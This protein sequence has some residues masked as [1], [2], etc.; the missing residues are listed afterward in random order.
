MP[1][2][3]IEI[4]A[5]AFV[6]NNTAKELIQFLNISKGA[7]IDPY[8]F[9]S[10]KQPEEYKETLEN[11]FAEPEMISLFL[12]EIITHLTLGERK[13]PVN[14]KSNI[15]WLLMK[16]KDQQNRR[17]QFGRTLALSNHPTLQNWLLEKDL[18][19]LLF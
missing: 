15:K 8:E 4:I 9:L 18:S 7:W 12:Q 5:G 16:M 13:I 6:E 3:D 2:D 10:S 14:A 19:E 1:E 17:L 11:I